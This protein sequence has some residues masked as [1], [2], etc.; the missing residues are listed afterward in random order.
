MLGRAAVGCCWEI[1]SIIFVCV[2]RARNLLAVGYAMPEMESA[3]ART[4]FPTPTS[5]RLTAWPLVAILIFFA[6]LWLEA[7]NQLK[8]EWSLNPQYSYGWSVPLLAL[9]LIWRRWPHRPAAAPRLSWKPLPAATL[10]IGAFLIL[11]LRFVALANPDWRLISWAMTLLAIALTLSCLF[12]MGGLPWLRHFAFPIVFFL[13]AVPWPVHFEQVIVQNLMG[14]VT[15]I[16]VALLNTVGVPALQLGNVIE[17]GS[18]LI[19]IEDACSGVRSLQATLMVSLFLG[20]LYTFKIGPRVLLVAAGV[21]LA[22][23]CN[24]VRT[25]FLVWIGARNGVK[26]IEAWHDPVGLTILLVCLLGLWLLCLLVSRNP[27]SALQWSKVDVISAPR[28]PR[29][30]SGL[31]AG[32]GIWICL[33]E[34]GVQTWYDLHQQ[35][36]TNTRWA[37]HWPVS[38]RRYRSVSIPLEAK[39]L[40][41][42]DEGGGGQWEAADGHLW[43]M[44]FF[45]W[46]PGRTAA[47]FVKN[48]RPDICLP[49]SGMTM[50]RDNGLRLVG[51]NG[52]NLPVHS[53]RF[54]DRGT[55]LHVFYCYWDA[56]SSYENV[57]AAEE[58]DWTACGRLRAALRGR[59]ETGAQMLEVV[60]WGYEDDK[61]ASQVLQ[62]QLAQIIRLG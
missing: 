38:Q 33:A 49:A 24:L 46:F 56:R 15:G 30:L 13:V 23:F 31:L 19:G 12:L 54:D 40:L 61:A 26:A 37:V 59:R 20:E 58:E 11:P 1:P 53:Y 10:V 25:A 32:V 51:V 57:A 8:A 50:E 43:M 47:L 55:P 39:R 22:F 27:N 41:R 6:P 62:R 3:V 5:F 21:L 52:V 60:V 18:G 16:N 34:A 48:H 42:Y 36:V 9:Y 28:P 4:R 35:S 7:I 29:K 45:C 17:V 14:A 44:Y 2:P